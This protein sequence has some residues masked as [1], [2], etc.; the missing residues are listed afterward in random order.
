MSTLYT[1]F[2]IYKLRFSIDK[3]APRDYMKRWREL[4]HKCEYGENKYIIEE[5]K[6]CCLLKENKEL[7]YLQRQEGGLGGKDNI[8]NK[9][10]R[11]RNSLFSEPW[12]LD[13]DIV[14]DEINN[15]E[16]EKWKYEEINDLL[17]AF[18]KVAAKHI[19][20]KNCLR[21]RIEMIPQHIYRY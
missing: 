5:I 15:T 2:Y 14:M 8:V 19:Q 11:F 18:M 1:N 21:G 10:I 20:S 13:N 7:P 4:K 3:D 9:Q 16:F 12:Q 17:Y 6:N